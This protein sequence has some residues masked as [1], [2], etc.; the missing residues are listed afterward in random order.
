MDTLSSDLFYDILTRLDGAT[1]V[2]AACACAAFSAISK[3]KDY[4]KMFALQYL[5][6]RDYPEEW[7]E[8]EYYGDYDELENV[9]PSDFVSIVDI[10]YKEKTI[11]SKVIWGIPTANVYNGW[12]SD[13]PFR[14]DL[15]SHPARDDDHAVKCIITMKFHIVDSTTLNLSEVFMQLG[16]MEGGHVNGRNSLV[17]LKE[18]LSCDRSND[19][20]L[21]LESCRLYS[22]VQDQIKEEK[23]RHE[24]KLERLEKSITLYLD[25]LFIES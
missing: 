7:T 13:C 11:C 20:G 9:S 25:A 8:A 3:E 18:A 1:L 24:N 22:K 15:F 23:I 16:N 12:F 14:I 17:V 2:S 4:G 10:K 6:W 21:V 19:Y 5:S